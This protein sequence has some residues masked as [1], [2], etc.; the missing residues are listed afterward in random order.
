MLLL[1]SHYIM[2]NTFA[3]PWTIACQAPLSKEFSRQIYCNALAFPSARNL[4]DSGIKPASPALAGRFFITKP[5]GKLIQPYKKEQILPFFTIWVNMED[6]MLSEIR[7]SRKD[8]YY[9]ILL[10]QRIEWWLLEGEGT[11]KWEVVQKFKE[12]VT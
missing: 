7:Q 6:I 8:K 3:T 10:K 5:P 9:M 1:F 11:E 2:S 12:T 4:P